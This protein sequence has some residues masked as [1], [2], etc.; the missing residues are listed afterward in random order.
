MYF[1][2]F[3]YV[4]NIFFVCILRIYFCKI[5]NYYYFKFNMCLFYTLL[6]LSSLSLV[7]GKK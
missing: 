1:N 5:Y 3:N 6:R 7:L 2:L 4:Q